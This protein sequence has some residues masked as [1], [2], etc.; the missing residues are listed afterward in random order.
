MKIIKK[1]AG[2]HSCKPAIHHP[3]TGGNAAPELPFPNRKRG[4]PEE[5]LS[6]PEALHL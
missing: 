2:E 4:I 3:F 1:R 6:V 5:K